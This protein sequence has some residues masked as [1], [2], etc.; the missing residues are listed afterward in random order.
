M[1]TVEVVRGV[2]WWGVLSSVAAPVVLI[3][4]W[5]VAA[6]LQPVLA[7]DKQRCDAVQQAGA[8]G[9]FYANG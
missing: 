2:P 6:A 5:T 3:G 9:A 8:N 7:A 1:L 4:G